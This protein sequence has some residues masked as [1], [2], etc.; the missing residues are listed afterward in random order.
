MS[1]QLTIGRTTFLVRREPVVTAS[2]VAGSQEM[3]TSFAAAW[4]QIFNGT[5]EAKAGACFPS[6]LS[7]QP[8]TQR[9]VADMEETDDQK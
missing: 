8:S 9:N 3:K 2:R 4:M 1:L 6:Q 7:A 5:W